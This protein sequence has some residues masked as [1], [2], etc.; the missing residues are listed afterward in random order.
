MSNLFSLQR[1]TFEYANGE[2]IAYSLRIDQK[3]LAR[4]VWQASTNKN[5]KSVRGCISVEAKK[6]DATAQS[7]LEV[8][9]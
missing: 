8:Q 4:F 7:Q 9:P 6:L 1:G 3:A 5:G 2:K